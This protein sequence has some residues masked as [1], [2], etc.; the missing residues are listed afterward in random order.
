MTGDSET[1]DKSDGGWPENTDLNLNAGKFNLKE[2]SDGVCTFISNAIE[3]VLNYVALKNAYPNLTRKGDA[4]TDA[5]L[6]AAK[7]TLPKAQC[8][9][10]KSS[11]YV[12]TISTAVRF[13]SMFGFV[14][15]CIC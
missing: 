9:T 8:R 13:L 7:R 2:Q 6:L 1:T 14:N 4:M 3:M 10:M 12:S 5:L 15:S 11:K